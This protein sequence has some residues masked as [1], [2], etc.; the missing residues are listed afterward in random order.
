MD[1][2]IVIDKRN[3]Q[4][5]LF[6]TAYQV[7]VFLLGRPVQ[8]YVVVKR[9]KGVIALKKLFETATLEAACEAA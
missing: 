5:S 2:Y 8:Q 6:N 9:G 3:L 1:N 7:S 4:T